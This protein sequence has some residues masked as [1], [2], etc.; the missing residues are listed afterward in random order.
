V[1]LKRYVNLYSHTNGSTTTIQ[2]KKE[3]NSELCQ[4]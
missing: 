4:T 3:H 2:K 1:P